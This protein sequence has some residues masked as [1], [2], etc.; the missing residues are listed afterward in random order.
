MTYSIGDLSRL[1]GLSVKTIRYY[2]KIG[3]LP[4]PQRAMNNYR[5]YDRGLVSRLNFIQRAKSMGFD[6]NECKMLLD[7]YDDKERASADVKK[8]AQQRFEALEVEIKRLQEMQATLK[9]LI[10]LCQGSRNP[11]CPILLSLEKETP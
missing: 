9:P 7:L 5:I 3:L 11:D 2:E 8:L 4:E 10:N 6:L 1:T